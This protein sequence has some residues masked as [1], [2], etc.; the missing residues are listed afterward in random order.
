MWRVPK[1]LE[2]FVGGEETALAPE[3]GVRG[4]EAA[5]PWREDSYRCPG[6]LDPEC[7][8]REERATMRPDA[9]TEKVADDCREARRD[10]RNDRHGNASMG[11]RTG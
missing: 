5:S 10:R 11:C 6:N 1:R 4:R 2:G 7:P 8:R 9:E 3:P